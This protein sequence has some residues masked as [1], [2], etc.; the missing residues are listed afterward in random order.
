MTDRV[1]L[2]RLAY[3]P[4]EV[5]TMLGVSRSLVYEWVERGF[6]PSIRNG[7]TIVIPAADLEAWV[8]AETRPARR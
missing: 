5:A 4:S 3:R 8:A 6:L 7:S 2:P 1:P